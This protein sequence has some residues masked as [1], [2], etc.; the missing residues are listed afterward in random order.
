[1]SSTLRKL[2]APCQGARMSRV[3]RQLST[4]GSASGAQ[5]IVRGSSGELQVVGA[6]SCLM[7]ERQA[8]SNILH[9]HT[10]HKGSTKQGEAWA[11]SMASR[12][13]RNPSA[14]AK[15]SVMQ[16]AVCICLTHIGRLPR[17]ARAN[18]VKLVQASSRDSRPWLAARGLKQACCIQQA[19]LHFLLLGRSADEGSHL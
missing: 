7:V 17:A 4:S 6:P 16:H 9:L 3:A 15:P 19:S 10:P 12:R 1:M 5:W 13:A 2:R 8:C 18:S 11:A 14:A